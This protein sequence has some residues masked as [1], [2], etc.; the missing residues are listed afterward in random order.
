MKYK[1][2]IPITL[3]I[4]LGL[5]F[6]KIFFDNYKTTSLT[7]FDEKDKIY[8]LQTGVYSSKE[9]MKENFK[10]YEKYLYIELEDGHHL[11]LGITKNKE[12]ASK[13]K[14]YYKKLGYSIYVKETIIDNQEFLSVLGEYDKILNIAT[15][16]DIPEIEK[17]VISNYKEMVLN[18]ET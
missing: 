8:M 1:F 6:G 11:Y 4:V 18:N 5:F 3:S 12:I 10:N 17:I 7:V 2:L 14:E 9:K 13:L 16:K 15:E